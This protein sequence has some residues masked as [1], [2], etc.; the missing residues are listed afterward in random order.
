MRCGRTQTKIPEQVRVQYRDVPEAS[1]RLFPDRETERDELIV[2]LNEEGGISARLAMRSCRDSGEVALPELKSPEMSPLE[3]ILRSTALTDGAHLGC[4][5]S[6]DVA[7]EASRI[8]GPL[9]Q[10][11]ERKQ[12]RTVPYL[13]EAQDGPHSAISLCEN[14]N[15]RFGAGVK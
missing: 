10:A 4:L 8:M 13:K 6:K 15:F 5:L 1:R 12:V 11:V 3:E 2:E 7:S 14:N 9:L